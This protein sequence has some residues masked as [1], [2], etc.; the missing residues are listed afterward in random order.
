MEFPDR[1]IPGTLRRRY[2]RFLA[3][4]VLEDGTPVT[5][6]CP[7]TG[8]MI[9]GCTPG[10]RVWL[11]PSRDPRRRTRFTWELVELAEGV[12]VGVNTGRSNALVREAIEAGMLPALQRYPVIRAE[13]RVPD[14]RSRLDFRL[15]TMDGAGACFVEVKNVTAAVEGGVAL[16][17]DAVS[18]RGT[19]HLREMGKL[20]ERGV[21]A[22]LV[23]AVQRADVRE[24]RPAD[25]IDPDYGT[26]LR[27]VIGKG[28]VVEA[29]RASVSQQGIRLD[30]RIPVACP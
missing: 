3:D 14:T 5:A 24:V 2:Q 23:F 27:E 8:S 21:P 15:S 26:A 18:V 19:R 17:P 12:L 28:V 22:V 1:L 16:F 13:A 7:N 29:R 4:V 9:G 6:H 10:S 25:E 20:V 30:A 11:S